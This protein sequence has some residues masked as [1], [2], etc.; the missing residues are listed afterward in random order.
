MSVTPTSGR[1]TLRPEPKRHGQRVFADWL[2]ANSIDPVAVDF[3]HGV[4]ID[5]DK[6]C[7]LWRELGDSTLVRVML[8]EP[9]AAVLAAGGWKPWPVMRRY[10]IPVDGQ[11]HPIDAAS[12]ISPGVGSIALVAADRTT[13]V[14]LWAPHFFGQ[15]ALGAVLVAYRDEDPIPGWRWLQH[16]GSAIPDRPAAGFFPAIGPPRAVHLF[17]IIDVDRWRAAADQDQPATSDQPDPQPDRPRCGHP[18]CIGHGDPGE[19]C[20]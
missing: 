19:K 8:V 11:P 6:R 10:D 18:G 7:L 9:D 16:L 1:I 13:R 20:C 3:P 15:P 12:C 5:Y 17:R 14:S 2:Q 4:T